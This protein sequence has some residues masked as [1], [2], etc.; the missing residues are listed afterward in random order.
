MS[1]VDFHLFQQLY[2]INLEKILYNTLGEGISS[3]LHMR[4][5]TYG[6]GSKILFGFSVTSYGKTEPFWFCQAYISF[7]SKCRPMKYLDKNLSEN[8]LKGDRPEATP[9]LFTPGSLQFCHGKTLSGLTRWWLHSEWQ[10]CISKRKPQKSSLHCLISA[11]R[12]TRGQGRVGLDHSPEC[13]C[14][15]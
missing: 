15:H 12:Q 10:L 3:H 6:V 8:P 7:A 9:R 13:S 11:K 2:Y 4:L 14:Q 5:H 1:Q